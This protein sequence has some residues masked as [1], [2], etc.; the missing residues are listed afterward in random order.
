MLS[1][2]FAAA[3][4]QQP[5]RSSSD[6]LIQSLECFSLKL[7][8]LSSKHVV[9]MSVWFHMCKDPG[10]FSISTMVQATSLLAANEERPSYVVGYGAQPGN[11]PKHVHHRCAVAAL[12]KGKQAYCACILTPTNLLNSNCKHHVCLYLCLTVTPNHQASQLP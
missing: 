3:E 12:L 4:E 11:W 9:T 2:M 8:R 1:L 6:T 7:V 10:V 5:G